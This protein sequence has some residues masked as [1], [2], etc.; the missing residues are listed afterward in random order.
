MI[1][2]PARPA[3][4][5][6][7]IGKMQATVVELHSLSEAS[8]SRVNEIAALGARLADDISA[9]RSGLSAG[10]LFDEVVG[11]AVGEL[12]RMGAQAGTGALEGLDGAQTR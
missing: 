10:V 6:E 2:A 12:Q 8:L 7:V 5:D 9:V 11:C 3:G 1:T 4:T